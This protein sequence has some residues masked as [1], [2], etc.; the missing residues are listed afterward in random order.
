MRRKS[1]THKAK[2]RHVSRR[3][4]GL[5]NRKRRRARISDARLQRG[6]RILRE[7]KDLL[8]A[9]RAARTTPKRFAAFALKKGAIRKQGKRWI[10]TRRLP[11]RMLVYSAGREVIVTVPNAASASL[12]GRYMAA[13]RQF[14]RTNKPDVLEPFSGRSVKD[15]A[16]KSHPFVADPNVVYRLSSVSDQAFERIYRIVV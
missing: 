4:S 12:I 1:Q 5:I 9:A 6:L 13:V 14:L 3:K 2:R 10:V 15:I 11:R 7:V 16:G 8:A